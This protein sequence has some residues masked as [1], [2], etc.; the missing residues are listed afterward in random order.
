MS[1]STSSSMEVKKRVHQLFEEQVEQSLLST[2]LVLGD[3]ALSYVQLNEKANQ[4]AR[5]LRDRGVGR[6]DFVGIG[7]ERSFDMYIAVLA[8]L[9]AGGVCVPFDSDYPKERLEY[10]LEDVGV[11]LLVTQTSLAKCFP[12]PENNIFCLDSNWSIVE[13]ELT[14]NLNIEG[15][16][17][18][19]AY[20]YYTSG[21][22]GRP[23]G[24]MVPHQGIVRLVKYTNYHGF[25]RD[26]VFLQYSSISFDAATFEIWGSLLNGSLLVIYPSPTIDIFEFG[27]ILIRLQV[28]T[29]W[30][31]AG[32]FPLVVDNQL[33]SLRSLQTI[34]VGGDVVSAIH[35]KK[36][37]QYLP[38]IRVVNAYG[39]TENTTFS[40]FFEMTDVSQI[41]ENIPIGRS[42]NHSEAFVFDESGVPVVMGD[43]GELYVGG[44]GLARGYLN[45]PELSR[46][47]FIPHPLQTNTDAKLYRTGDLV[48]QR[49]DGNLEF[50]GRIDQQVKIRGFRIE[51]SEIEAQIRNCANVLN[52]VV[53]VVTKSPSDKRIG[54]YFIAEP[55]TVVTAKDVR[56]DLQ[57]RLPSYMMPTYFQQ[58]EEFPLTSNGKIDKNRLPQ[59]DASDR[60]RSLIEPRTETEMR[61]S[62]LWNEVLDTPVSSLEDDF[63][64]AGGN[65]LLAIKLL[66]RIS[67][68][69]GIRLNISVIFELL[70]LGDLSKRIERE[71]KNNCAE[72]VPVIPDVDLEYRRL[73]L[74]QE[75]LWMLDQ[76]VAERSAYNIVSAYRMKGV[77]DTAV[78]H[79]SFL[80]MIE[81]HEIL[82][83]VFTQNDGDVQYQRVESFEVP[84]TIIE[85]QKFN[86]DER[87]DLFQEK[88]SELMAT[89]FNL[90]EGPLLNLTLFQMTAEEFVF[91][92]VAH[93]IILDGWSLGIL[94]NEISQFYRAEKRGSCQ[95]IPAIQYRYADY[96][97][98]QRENSESSKVRGDLEYWKQQL[99]GIPDL[100]PLPTDYQ[101][102]VVESN[103]GGTYYFRVSHD[104]HAKLNSHAKARGMTLFMVM[105]AAYKTLLFRYTGQTDITV[106]TH[107]AGRETDA[108][109]SLIG[110]FVNTLVLRTDFSEDLSFEE[111]LK[112]VKRVTLEAFSHQSLRFEQLVKELKPERSLGWNP[113]FQ[114]AFVL[115]NVDIHNWN[116]PNVEVTPFEAKQEFSKFDLSLFMEET[117][118]GLTGKLVY[119]LDLFKATT[120]K[121]MM[122][123]YLKLLQVMVEE[124]DRRVSTAQLVS[125]NEMQ[126]IVAESH[127]ECMELSHSFLFTEMFEQVAATYS[128]RIALIYEDKQYTYQELNRISNQVAH[129]LQKVGV[130]PGKLVG[131]YLNRSEKLLI[132]MLG[133]LKAGGAYVPFD[134]KLPKERMEFMIQDTGLV[135]LITEEDS[136]SAGTSSTVIVNLEQK[137]EQIICEPDW[138][139]PCANHAE[140]PIYLIYTSG[141]TGKP[142]GVVIEHRNLLN[143]LHGIIRV[144]K[145]EPGMSFATVSSL[146]ADL[147]NTMIFPALS[148][149]GTL[150]II[151]SER[152][153]DAEALAEYFGRHSIDF[154]KIV[155]SHFQAL[156][157]SDMKQVLPQKCLVFGGE[158]LRTRLLNK[159]HQVSPELVVMNHY[160][161]T[162]TTVGVLAYRVP[163]HTGGEHDAIVPLGRPLAN[164]IA[165]ILDAKLQPVPQGVP[166]ELYIGGAGVSKG[167]LGNPE[168]TNERFIPDP[169]SDKP[170]SY[171]YKSGDLVCRT[172]NGLISFIGRLDHQVKIRGYRIEP[173]DIESALL[174]YPSVQ[175]AV[176]IAH[177]VSGEQARL[178]AYVVLVELTNATPAEVRCFLN[179]KIPDYMIPTEIVFLSEMPLNANGKINR[180]ALPLPELSRVISEELESESGTPLEI[181][182]TSIWREVLGVNTINRYDNFFDLGGHSLLA[183]QVLSRIRKSLGINITLRDLF[184]AP[185]IYQLS[186]V[187]ESC[188]TEISMSLSNPQELIVESLSEMDLDDLSDEDVEKLLINLLDGE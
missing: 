155:P 41:E 179:Q 27:E 74:A 163:K 52:T 17:E 13:K 160:G 133:I 111:L 89:Q 57:S 9:K 153:M 99:S 36:V 177:S 68:E 176:V 143:Y 126:T 154:L 77:L 124:P 92:L 181:E 8:I 147:G 87:E 162:E 38:G 109:D 183:T 40:T 136:Q 34:F 117:Q 132:A 59:F 125:A 186:Q 108:F 85:L 4:L 19:L 28:T 31:T 158:S 144:M 98:W 152:V 121:R 141:T 173:G 145:V 187:V 14:D 118:Q 165:Y 164:S 76:L 146:A 95:P 51:L 169:Y 48:S 22:T 107:A 149:G 93:H 112:L 175:E 45:L 130:G 134:T 65:S 12:L 81:R 30:M 148:T 88:L 185:T 25:H 129:F 5:Y 54:A 39:P 83:T 10:M 72:N 11:S 116:L 184:Q 102:P 172:E 79:R 75:Q 70:K 20:I 78:L 167:Y 127:G 159:I 157:S 188:E 16:P 103:K 47:K 105:L 156:S 58:L 135:A 50:L 91:V 97:K 122:D 113:L 139:L 63:L 178:I 37:L 174:S 71:L 86:S 170:N 119:R 18:D 171:L 23:K 114:A 42:I 82:R 33:D 96:A 32:F 168:L 6:G 94:Y 43:P 7:M 55:G 73:S 128:N 80:M 84:L 104:L 110:Y 24:V 1:Y 120:I 123:H 46:E 60:K 67:A 3:H 29:L 26:E 166:G 137:W 21:S 151:S 44:A 101:R 53:T 66:T 69:F 62:A 182:L 15:T 106:G 140:D 150:H 138:N 131:I 142:K 161:P 61:L 49:P 64:E 2:A 35:V 56:Q 180:G 90:E 100:L 115:Q